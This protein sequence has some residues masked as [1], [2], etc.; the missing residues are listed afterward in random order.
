MIVFDPDGGLIIASQTHNRIR[1][2]DPSGTISTIAGIELGGSKYDDGDGGPAT[3]ARVYSPRDVAIG[4]DGLLYIAGVYSVRRILSDGTIETYVS[5]LSGSSSST[6]RQTIRLSVR[7]VESDGQSLILDATAGVV[8][9]DEND[10]LVVLYPAAD[11]PS[12]GV[13][14]VQLDGRMVLAADNEVVLLGN[15][16]VRVAGLGAAS[17]RGDGGPATDAF[18]SVPA[19]LE[20]GPDGSIYVADVGLRQIRRIA[21][22]GMITTAYSG[23]VTDFAVDKE[24]NLFVS[25]GLSIDKIT[26]DG[27]RSP[28]VGS[29]GA[30]GCA[31]PVC[32]EGVSAAGMPILRVPSFDVD[33]D[34]NVY[35]IVERPNSSYLIKV[36]A[37]GLLVWRGL[38]VEAQI[39]RVD[40]EGR[41]HIPYRTWNIVEP[42]GQQTVYEGL[43]SYAGLPAAFSV[44]PDGA[45]YAANPYVSLSAVSRYTEGLISDPIAGGLDVG[46]AGDGGPAPAALLDSVRGLMVASDGALYI[47][48]S[49]NRRVRRVTRAGECPSLGPRAL[50]AVS[51]PRNGANYSFVAPGS[52]FTLFGLR[53]GPAGLQTA[54]LQSGNRLPTRLAGTRILFDGVAAPLLYV[55]AG[56]VGGVV[57]FSSPV[58]VDVDEYG[59]GRWNGPGPRVVVETDV[60]RSDPRGHAGQRAHS[61][62]PTVS[63]RERYLDHGRT[64]RSELRCEDLHRG[65]A[66]EA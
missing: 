18:L 46:F 43:G 10:E 41:I 35:A 36:D 61:E 28:F 62:D 45:I 34:G 58:N 26:P 56:Q 4:P 57:P 37:Q 63:G 27:T 49:R 55:S 22:D 48:D 32:A 53:L 19:R 54:T 7:G 2:V 14:S 30:S 42:N 66:A 25:R 59:A 44:A 3:E 8:R 5:G 13:L 11:L 15:P 20:E 21:P 64:G 33:G 47:S 65:I 51:G 38:Q 50:P 29:L 17:K 40:F 6:Q 16:P 1:R 24:N 60:G 31:P 39:L 9:F 12:D 23:P 52:V